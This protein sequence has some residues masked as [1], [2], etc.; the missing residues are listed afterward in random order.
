MND[1]LNFMLKCLH[2]GS[3]YLFSGAAVHIKTESPFNMLGSIGYLIFAISF[4]I[5]VAF[6]IKI[7]SKWLSISVSML[8]AVIPVIIYFFVVYYLFCNNMISIS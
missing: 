3:T 7:K 5:F 8:A 6:V 1:F 4:L 2:D